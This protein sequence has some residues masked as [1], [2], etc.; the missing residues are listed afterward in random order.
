MLKLSTGIRPKGRPSFIGRHRGFSLIEVMMSIVL[1]AIGTALAIPSF[2]DQVEK[3][4]ITNGAEQLASFVNMAQGAAMRSNNVVTVSWS[5]TDSNN[6]CIGAV[7]GETACDCTVFTRSSDSFCQIDSDRYLLD[8]SI[9]ASDRGLVHQ[10]TGD[11]AYSF[12]PV[13]GIFV[14]LDDDLSMQLRSRSGDFRLNLVVNN[15]GRVTLCSDDAAHAV[16]GY[17]VCA[18]VLEGEDMGMGL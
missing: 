7:E 1:V 3:R 6:W 16:P 12:D 14:D 4:Q 2:G 17:D 15:T 10:V 13:R 5:F 9:L 11:G 8:D 18:G